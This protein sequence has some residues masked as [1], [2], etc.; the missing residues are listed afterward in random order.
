MARVRALAE[1]RMVRNPPVWRGESGEERT[2]RDE[3]AKDKS[4]GGAALTR[5]ARIR[6]VL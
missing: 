1:R 5:I 3:A 6:R 4:H 2:T